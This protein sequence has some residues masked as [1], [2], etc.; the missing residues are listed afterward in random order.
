VDRPAKGGRGAK[1]P[2]VIA[3]S[4]RGCRGPAC[5]GVELSD[6]ISEGMT[7]LGKAIIKFDETKGF[8]FSTYAHWWIRQPISRA[9]SDE[10]R[11]VRL[12]VHVYENLGRINKVARELNSQEGREE[13]ATLREIGALPCARMWH[14][15]KSDI[16]NGCQM[17]PGVLFGVPNRTKRILLQRSV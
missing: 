15:W 13:P 8:K 5:R 4:L 16:M 11:I 7:G 3:A 12:P 2:A 1:Q 6:L 9:V 10:S 14:H 17:G